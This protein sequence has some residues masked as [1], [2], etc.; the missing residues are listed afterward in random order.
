MGCV[1]SSGLFCLS[2]ISYERFGSRSLLIS[3]GLIN[4]M[5]RMTMWWFLLRACNMAAPP[6]LNLLGEIGLLS[7]LVSWSWCL[8]FV[9][10]FLSFFSAAYT[11]YMYSYSQHGSIYSGLYS[12]SLGYVR[13]FLLLFLH[14]FPYSPFFSSKCLLFHNATYFGSCI[15]N[16]LHT[17]CAKI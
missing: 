4:L 1:C 12:C 14:W 9:L 16:N 5:P 2:N 15:I 3:R 6:S 17:G 8:M 11:L 10:V 7:R 13:E